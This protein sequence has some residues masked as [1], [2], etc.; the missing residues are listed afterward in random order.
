MAM[1][2][3]LRPA[4]GRREPREPGT[5]LGR[6][7]RGVEMA[8]WNVADVWEAVADK[9]P[10]APSQIQGDRTVTWGEFDRRA[11]AL[12]ADLLAAGLQQQSEV[13]AYLYNCP[14]Y[15]E[16]YFAAFKTGLVPVNTNY[17][18]GP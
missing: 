10:D 1:T 17:R 13:A 5:S 9:V 6:P 14:E 7:Q 4:A 8:G 18:Y 15:L 12:A 11:N 2:P 3:R 16:T